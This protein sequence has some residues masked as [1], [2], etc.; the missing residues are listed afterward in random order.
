M[1]LGLGYIGAVL[2]RAGHTVKI[3]DMAIEKMSLEK[4]KTCILT[5]KPEVIGLTGIIVE[6]VQILKIASIC[7]ESAETSK[8]I[9]GGPLASSM[10]ETLLLNSNIDIVVIGEGELTIIETIGRIENNQP[11]ESVRGIAYR[12]KG[13]PKINPLREPLN[14]DT[15][16][17]PARHLLPMSQYIS[18]FEEWFGGDTGIRT[19]N[20]ISGRGC[21]YGC[22]YCDHN[23]FG[24]KWRGRSADNMVDEMAFLNERYHINGIIFNDDIFDL[25]K[26]RVYQICDEIKQRDLDII[27]GCNSRANHANK[28]MY[29]K[30][31][32]SGCRYVAFGI[33]SGNQKILDSM[34]KNLTL[35]QISDAV[36]LAKDVGLA[37]I[38]YFMIG[39]LGED[40][41]TIY[42][43][44]NFARRLHLDAG[45]FA[46]TVP[47]PRTMLY[48]R[49]T[50]EEVITGKGDWVKIARWSRPERHINLTRDLTQKQLVGI[51]NQANWEL[52][53][54]SPSRRPPRIV[55]NFL[56]GLS[57]IVRQFYPIITHALKR[58]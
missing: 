23:V 1:P 25:D 40:R 24:R 11:I 6:F 48:E 55:C 28:E 27:W 49:A 53:W 39:M 47:L 58:D 10:P 41:R 52:Y 9:V 19:T 34:Q 7:K 5:F 44:I 35:K 37:T 56:C 46:L 50:K 14:I 57:P 32:K 45:G 26:K 18:P 2:E 30:M 16:P 38:G 3:I 15:L 4:L 12:V 33:E 22:I 43:T 13:V 36:K 42:D 21:P 8:V 31:Q 54:S 20:M 51:L 29:Q 17:F